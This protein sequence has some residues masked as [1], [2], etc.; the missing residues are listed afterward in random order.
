MAGK[1]YLDASFGYREDILENWEK[2]NPLLERGE[3]S[4]VRDG[5]DGK[6]VKI[7][8]G[9]TLWNELPYAPLP[10]GEKGE[11]GLP[12]ERGPSGK[13]GADYILTEDD[14]KEIADIIKQDEVIGDID[15]AIDIIISFQNSLIGGDSE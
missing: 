1:I 3:I 10:K 12:G 7:G 6:F 11:R 5:A 2:S 14:K 15:R 13:D 4:F 8:D 9:S